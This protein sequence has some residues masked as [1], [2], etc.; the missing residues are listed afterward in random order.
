M[1]D[2][3]ISSC[4][5]IV[6]ISAYHIIGGGQSPQLDASI[7]KVRPSFIRLSL[8]FTLHFL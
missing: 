8:E 4:L 6:E 3:L 1:Y 2:V 7:V 5:S